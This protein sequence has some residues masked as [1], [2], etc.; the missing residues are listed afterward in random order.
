MKFIS[1]L[2]RKLSDSN[3]KRAKINEVSFSQCVSLTEHGD[4]HTAEKMWKKILVNNES[5][6]PLSHC[7]ERPKYRQSQWMAIWKETEI[8]GVVTREKKILK[9]KQK[10]GKEKK[11]V[12][13]YKYTDIVLV[14]EQINVVMSL[15]YH[16]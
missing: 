3:Y 10:S 1:G 16:D 8:C 2:K 4:W 15:D 5:R 14:S 6:N 13:K 7:Y 11:K 12:D 9:H